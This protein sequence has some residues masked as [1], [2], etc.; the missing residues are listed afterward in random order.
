MLHT[1]LWQWQ[2]RQGH[3]FWWY[4]WGDRRHH[5]PLTSSNILTVEGVLYVWG[6]HSEVYTIWY[7]FK[8]K[9]WRCIIIWVI[10]TAVKYRRFLAPYEIP[11][12][13]LPLTT[14]PRPPITVVLQLHAVGTLSTQYSLTGLS[15]SLK[16]WF[17]DDRYV[18]VWWY[19]FFC[20]WIASI[21]W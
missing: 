15:R 10:H 13:L 1:F 19:H 7:K 14:L 16:Q 12:Y 9:S 17:V 8:E 21:S 11:Y 4:I 6:T 3:R 18:T 20:W 5:Y 2:W